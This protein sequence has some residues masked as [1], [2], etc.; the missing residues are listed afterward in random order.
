[1]SEKT[2]Q[3]QSDHSFDFE[4]E[5]D[6]KVQAAKK[7]IKEELKLH[8]LEVAVR[9][10]V[11]VDVMA[12]FEQKCSEE[13]ID[14]C[15][16]L[17]Q[18]V[19]SYIDIAFE[20][21]RC[22]NMF[23]NFPQHNLNKLRRLLRPFNEEHASMLKRSTLME[24]SSLAPRLASILAP[25]F[26]EEAK[27]YEQVS[28]VLKTFLMGQKL[29]DEQKLLF[30]TDQPFKSTKVIN[31]SGRDAMLPT[32]EEETKDSGNDLLG[33]SGYDQ[34]SSALSATSTSMIS[35]EDDDAE[36]SDTLTHLTPKHGATGKVLAGMMPSPR[37]ATLDI[38]EKS[39]VILAKPH[40]KDASSA[41]IDNTIQSKQVSSSNLSAAETLKKKK[42]LSK[43][44]RKR[45][46]EQQYLLITS[47]QSG[48]RI[49]V[50]NSQVDD[51]DGQSDTK[52][53]KSS[54]LAPATVNAAI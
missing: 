44:A 52:V 39:L 12:T 26:E 2:N 23:M 25:L 27:F 37:N 29:S 47:E 32:T 19:V 1:M 4:D 51:D 9:K 14:R 31:K 45:R 43:R 41:A 49:T 5:E 18:E 20:M 38:S 46:R 21:K 34:I 11:P 16:E 10:V 13:T 40:A 3:V 30:S 48:N 33:S 35:L 15:A 50:V 8:C 22:V 28:E 54:S 53:S 36:K 24:V 42:K 17:R 7:Q 6:D